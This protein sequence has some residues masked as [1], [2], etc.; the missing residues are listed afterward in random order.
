M[1]FFFI[2]ESK[3]GKKVN[4]VW[5]SLLSETDKNKMKKG[6]IFY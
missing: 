2:K 4:E 6:D 5:K 1:N 3:T